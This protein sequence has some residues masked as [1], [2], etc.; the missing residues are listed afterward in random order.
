MIKSPDESWILKKRDRFFKGLHGVVAIWSHEPE[1]AVRYDQ[2]RDA[3]AAQAKVGGYI[4][5]YNA[6]TGELRL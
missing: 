4:W 5:R 3:A 2:Y 1:K 6:V